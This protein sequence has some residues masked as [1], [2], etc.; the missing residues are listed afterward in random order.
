MSLE[1]IDKYLLPQDISRSQDRINLLDEI[2]NKIHSTT[3]VKVGIRLKPPN[4]IILMCS[5]SS[6]TSELTHQREYIIENINQIL[7]DHNQPMIDNIIIRL[8]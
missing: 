6:A 1:K 5:S 3:K 2:K 7:E 8:S 4:T